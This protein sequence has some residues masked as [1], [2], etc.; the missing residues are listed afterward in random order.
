[1]VV[2]LPGI[3]GSVLQREDGEELWAISGR[4]ISRWVKTR[5]ESL[6]ELELEDPDRDDGIRATA[7][8]G[9]FHGV[10]GLSKF[11]GYDGLRRLFDRHFKVTF[12]ALE[13]VSASS[14]VRAA[15][16]ASYFEFPYDW[17]RDNRSSARQLAAFV[18]DALARWRTHTDDS[19]A[20]LILIAHSMGG[21]VCRYYL[22]VLEGWRDCR[23]LITFGTPYRGAVDA[24]GYLANGYKSALGDLTAMMRSFPSV[25]QLLPTYPLIRSAGR[26]Q[27][28]AE[29][30][31]LA[32]LEQPRAR[33][34]REEFHEAIRLKVE[35]NRRD[36]TYL[37]AGYKIVPF[38]GTAQPTYQSA[39]L[40][41]SGVELS[42]ALPPGVDGSLGDGDGRVP[43]VSAIPVELSEEYRDTYIPDGRHATLQNNPAMLRELH[44]RLKLMQARGLADLYGS[45]SREEGE[46]EPALRLHLDDLYLPGEPIALHAELMNPRADPGALVARLEPITP[47]GTHPP[48]TELRESADGWTGRL[49]GLAAG[50]YR[51][52]LTTTRRGEHAPST[53]TDVF[54]VAE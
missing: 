22:E 18:E 50:A 20:K 17:R 7:V 47:G 2:V 45:R 28:V 33:Q 51:I 29:T 38:A 27:R 5:G 19:D 43:R 6:H 53:L 4:A 32:H 13:R 44:E 34:A 35:E 54:E 31:G 36:E 15:R 46:R 14:T 9:G 52:E 39:E 8:M 10:P 12:G 1:M 49:E 23:A 25:Y 3:T 11:G 21:L 24:L 16:P 42:R 40:R 30:R 41:G 26:Y 37:T 48:G